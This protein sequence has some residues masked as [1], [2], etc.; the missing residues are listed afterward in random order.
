MKFVTQRALLQ[1][2]VRQSVKK[3][4]NARDVDKGLHEAYN[5]LKNK[6][7]VVNDESY[8]FCEILYCILRASD[9]DTREKTMNEMNKVMYQKLE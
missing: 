6:S 9:D 1:L 4:K 5:Y 8:I 2:V 3:T 7:K